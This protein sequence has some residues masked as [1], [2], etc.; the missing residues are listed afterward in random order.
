MV[1]HQ[2]KTENRCGVDNAATYKA[3]CKSVHTR[4]IR[5][6]LVSPCVHVFCHPTTILEKYYN[7]LEA[8][9]SFSMQCQFNAMSAQDRRESEGL[10]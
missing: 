3:L 9:A 8:S 4:P 1:S 5:A 2:L 6:A 7:G 10:Q